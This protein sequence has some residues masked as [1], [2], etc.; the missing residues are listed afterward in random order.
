MSRT[1]DG[2]DTVTFSHAGSQPLC[3]NAW[4]RN[5]QLNKHFM[6]WT[7]YC[8]LLAVNEYRHFDAEPMTASVRL[9]LKE[10]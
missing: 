7:E 9:Q 6:T 8:D 4:K 2:A 1:R 10:R 5:F 3:F